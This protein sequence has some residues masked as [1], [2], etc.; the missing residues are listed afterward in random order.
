[1]RVL[2]LIDSLDAGGAERCAVSLANGL[3]QEIEQSLIV[4]TRKEGIL[5]K[6]LGAKVSYFFLGKKSAFDLKALR[7]LKTI[8]KLIPINIASKGL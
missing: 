7:R 4:V 8:V 6:Q 3:A 2:Q 1:M 5:K